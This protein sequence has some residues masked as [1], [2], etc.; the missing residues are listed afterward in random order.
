M[1]A[2]TNDTVTAIIDLQ[3]FVAEYWNE[4]DAN[5]ARNMAD[6][7]VEDCTYNGSPGR[8]A[9]RKFYD[10]RA[11]MLREEKGGTRTVRH[12]FTNLRV[13]VDAPDRASLS[14]IL[15]NFAGAGKP[16]I[17]DLTGP[18]LISDMA[19]TCRRE[20]SGQW[21]IV[22]FGGQLLFVGNESFTNKVIAKM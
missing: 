18:A 1:V 12:T 5:E 21:R 4:L 2:T 20:A 19:W 7:Y 9:V 10:E 11:R 3:Q 15:I 8:E 14:F 22:T 16:P 6:F 13:R 17:T